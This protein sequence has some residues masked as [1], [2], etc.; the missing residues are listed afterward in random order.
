M[1][2]SAIDR[3]PEAWFTLV[4]VSVDGGPSL[5]FPCDERGLVVLDSL[6][7]RS[8]DSYL[9]ARALVGRHYRAP[10]VTRHPD[11]LG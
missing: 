3:T 8:R 6:S 9:L 1:S 5:E 10:Q 4:Y 11:A 2:D 7:D